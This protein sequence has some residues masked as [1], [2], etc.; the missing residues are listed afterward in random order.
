MGGKAIFMKDSV[1]LM[2]KKCSKLPW[3]TRWWNT[4]KGWFGSKADCVK[5]LQIDLGLCKDRTW[6]TKSWD[7]VKG[8]FGSKATC[9]KA[10]KKTAPAPA[11]KAKAPA[12]K[13]KASAP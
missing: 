6:Y 10:A 7:A 1:S 4:M 5:G 2:L 12:P 9:V 3:Y 8:V 13:A 11:P